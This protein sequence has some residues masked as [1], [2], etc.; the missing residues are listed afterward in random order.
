MEKRSSS[1]S[2]RRL[3]SQK[4][5]QKSSSCSSAPGDQSLSSSFPLTPVRVFFVPLH[6]FSFFDRLLLIPLF[7]CQSDV[8]FWYSNFSHMCFESRHNGMLPEGQSC[9]RVL[10][11][12]PLIRRRSTGTKAMRVPKNAPHRTE[13][14]YFA[15]LASF[16]EEPRT[17][18]PLSTLS[19]TRLSHKFVCF[20]FAFSS[21]RVSFPPAAW[22]SAPTLQKQPFFWKWISELQPCANDNCSHTLCRNELCFFLDY[23]LIRYTEG[24]MKLVISRRFTF[25]YNPWE[26]LC[27]LNLQDRVQNSLCYS[28]KPKTYQKK[29]GSHLDKA[30]IHFFAG[31]LFLLC[32]FIICIHG[33][34]KMWP[35]KLFFRFSFIFHE[36]S[37]IMLWEAWKESTDKLVNNP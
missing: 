25:F 6:S 22:F 2:V 9:R 7:S 23:E 31:F 27:V 17:L 28:W 35:A 20:S 3:S 32:S 21:S 29:Y 33:I 16:R 30:I 12:L 36:W 11:L 34:Q 18:P 1:F 8:C 15:A 26:K 19:S 14:N 10:P 5:R 37:L 4:V 13:F 24:S